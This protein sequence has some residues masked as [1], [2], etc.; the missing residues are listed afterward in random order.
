M[1]LC[2]Q[3]IEFLAGDEN[4]LAAEDQEILRN[5]IMELCESNVSTA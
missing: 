2:T 4:P 5:S 3:M 1:V